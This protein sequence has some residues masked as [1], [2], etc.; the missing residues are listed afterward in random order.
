MGFIKRFGGKV[1]DEE[2]W[3][4]WVWEEDHDQA[5]RAKL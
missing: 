3:E 4:K 5:L 1:P 2:D